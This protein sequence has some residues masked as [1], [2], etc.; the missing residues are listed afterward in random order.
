[1]KI[2]NKDMLEK[3]IRKNNNNMISNNIN[4]NK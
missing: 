4:N 1:M 3:K 2:I